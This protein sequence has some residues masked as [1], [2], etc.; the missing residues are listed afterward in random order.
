MFDGPIGK[1]ILFWVFMIGAVFIAKVL[2]FAQDTKTMVIYL[3][4]CAIAY[5][6]F[7]VGRV[8]ARRRKERNE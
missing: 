2:G 5:I 7:A 8:M 3:V 6:V 4:A 1:I